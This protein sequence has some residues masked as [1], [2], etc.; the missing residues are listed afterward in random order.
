MVIAI[1]GTYR[2]FVSH[3]LFIVFA[4]FILLIPV[5][6]LKLSF[7]KIFMDLFDDNELVFI[8]K[9]K[10]KIRKLIY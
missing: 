5:D 9:I 8:Q 7:L 10:I 4:G 6:K 1:V 3:S 2:A